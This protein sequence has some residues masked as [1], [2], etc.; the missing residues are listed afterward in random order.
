[1]NL[2]TLGYNEFFGQQKTAQHLETF[3]MARV[4]IENKERYVVLSANGEFE[5]QITGKLRFTANSK[6]D[7]PAVGD[8]VAITETDSNQAIIHE[9]IN[10]KSYLARKMVDSNDLQLIAANIDVAFIT[11][12][13][14]RDF[15]LNRIDR[16]LAII[17]TGKVQPAILLTKTDL[18]NE[19][20]LKSHIELLEKQY[21]GI[22]IY[23]LSSLENTGFEPFAKILEKGKTYCFLGSSGVGKST[24]INK[25]IGYN[26]QET[27]E[28][29]TT[30]NK[31]KH[32]TTRRELIVKE[33][34]ILIDTPGMREIGLT[35]DQEGID[36]TFPEIMALA[37]Q[38]KFQNCT[39]T[40]E[41]GCAVIAAIKNN[42]LNERTFENY[43]KL[44]R[45][46][47]RLEAS[48]EEKRKTDRQF[49][50]MCKQIMSEKKKS[51]Y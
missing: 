9:I 46:R 10:R 43:K 8:W 24:I 41:K 17:N 27:N 5:A 21:T 16:Y 38:C 30:T 18:A 3:Q 20:D 35:T 36:T 19:T 26:L 7:F 50:K 2:A 34:Y 11:T 13:V 39:H 23:S 1:M 42:E 44:E 12:S 51:K 6:M 40:S 28:L 45:E 14:D 15:N 32:T 33:N 37:G 47:T 31:G 49:G 25:L 4:I 22:S 48:I 29:S